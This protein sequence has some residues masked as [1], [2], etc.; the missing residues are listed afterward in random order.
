MSNVRMTAARARE[1]ALEALHRAEAERIAAADREAMHSDPEMA[2]YCQFEGSRRGVAPE[3]IYREEVA[4]RAWLAANELTHEELTRL[5][6]ASD[7][8]PRIIEG[9]EECPFS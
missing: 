4:A 2:V 8:N 5:A 6:A 7:P 1:I 9:D 3:V